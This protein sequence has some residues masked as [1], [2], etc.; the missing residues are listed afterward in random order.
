MEALK[1][2]PALLPLDHANPKPFILSVDTSYMAVGYYLSQEEADTTTRHFARFMSLPLSEREARFSQPKREL[3][4]L[5]R[6]LKA[7]NYWLIGC[8]RLVVE[9]D[10]MYIKGM[11]THPSMGLNA[12]I[13]RWI[14]DILMF[15]FT[16]KHV[17]GRVF[18]PDSLSRRPPQP[19]DKIIE[20]P[21]AEYDEI[22]GLVDIEYPAEPFEPLKEFEDFKADIDTRGG[23]FMAG[24]SLEDFE[25]DCYVATEEERLW[26]DT[27]RSKIVT[28]ELKNG[29][30]QMVA[31]FLG[32]SWVPGALPHRFDHVEE[33]DSP[34]QEDHRTE[35]GKRWDA[36][37]PL[38]RRYL[39][40]PMKEIKK[41]SE[42]QGWT[43][44][45]RRKFA[46]HAL[47]YFLSSQGKLYKRSVEGFHRAFVEKESRNR[48]MRMAHDSLGHRGYF[49]THSLLEKR[50]YWHE[51]DRDINQWVKSCHVCQERI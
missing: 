45:D 7:C 19:G 29:A 23:Y 14:K 25:R 49:A 15:H 9:T 5:L 17:P 38:I 46:W 12:T 11:L 51:M 31:Q 40:D 41:L 26:E 43:E 35:T 30:D 42:E 44:L 39:A 20:N 33:D 27:M 6:A 2:C 36:E 28:C 10:A 21:E 48:V 8:Q 32:E 50:L 4:G 18:G 24:G 47:T 13:N 16:L 3:F 1:N 22:E 37:V 34:Y